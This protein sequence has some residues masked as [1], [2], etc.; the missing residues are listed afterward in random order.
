MTIH[1]PRTRI[2]LGV[3]VT[4]GLASALTLSGPAVADVEGAPAPEVTLGTPES[5]ETSQYDY[6]E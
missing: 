3:G 6:I 1:R 5:G 4:A 2:T